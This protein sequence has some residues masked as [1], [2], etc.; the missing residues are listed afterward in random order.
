MKIITTAEGGMAL[1]NNAALAARL[2]RLRSYGI[3]RDPHLMSDPPDGSWYYQQI[4]LGFNYRMTDLHAALRVSQLARL[5]EYVYRRWA[6][7][8]RYDALLQSLPLH[9]PW[10]HPEAASALH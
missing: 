6:L 3:T 4:K 8:A 5:R 7:A 10:Y 2:D 1:T 9:R